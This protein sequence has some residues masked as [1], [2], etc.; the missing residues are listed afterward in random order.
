MVAASLAGIGNAFRMSQSADYQKVLAQRGEGLQDGSEFEILALRRR[1]PLVHHDSVGKIDERHAPRRFRYRAGDC[2]GR[3]MAWHLQ[4]LLLKAETRE[5][6]GAPVPVLTGHRPTV[7]I[8][9]RNLALAGSLKISTNIFVPFR[10]PH[11]TR[12]RDRARIRPFRARTCQAGRSIQCASRILRACSRV[13]V[14]PVAAGELR[15]R[16]EV[17]RR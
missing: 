12:T 3:D 14:R 10:S 15:G 13:A 1:R 16:R 9:Q 2:E 4:W 7:G 11:T 6:R 5:R 8:G 17:A